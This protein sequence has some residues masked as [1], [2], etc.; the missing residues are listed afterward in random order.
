[1]DTDMNIC[2]TDTRRI[3][4]CIWYNRYPP[5]GIDYPIYFYRLSG[6]LK[7]DYPMKLAQHQISRQSSYSIDRIVRA[8]S[9]LTCMSLEQ[10]KS[11]PEY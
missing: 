8:T 5:M 7:E 11:N 9:K 1:M 10:S 4:Q 6:V 2:Q 3:W